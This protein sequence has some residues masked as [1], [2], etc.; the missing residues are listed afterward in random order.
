LALPPFKVKDALREK[1]YR[2]RMA[3]IKVSFDL[4][5]GETV[6]IQINIPEDETWFMV[7][8]KHGDIPFKV[9]THQCIK[10]RYEAFPALLISR[11]NLDLPYPIPFIAE[12]FVRGI[13]KNVVTTT[14]HFELTI[15]RA[16][17]PRVYIKWL[18]RLIDFEDEVKRLM[19][20]EWEKMRPEEK[21]ATV[22]A[23]L[24]QFPLPLVME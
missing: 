4:A 9:F 2:C 23:W 12:E 13:I 15:F 24:R 1:M 17:A 18:R 5:A 7:L 6:V 20:E 8:D 16:L 22:R 3:L 21:R 14:E 19:V 11:D 10:D